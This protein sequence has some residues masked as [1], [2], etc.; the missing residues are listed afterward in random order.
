MNSNFDGKIMREKF[1]ICS[2]L[3][4]YK[5]E[6]STIKNWITFI[7]ERTYQSCLKMYIEIVKFS[8]KI[9]SSE[10]R[11]YLVQCYAVVNI[12]ELPAIKLFKEK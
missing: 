2:E 9:L 7:V 12:T 6:L 10:Q 5:Y 8:W 11:I 3:S 4:Y 1:I